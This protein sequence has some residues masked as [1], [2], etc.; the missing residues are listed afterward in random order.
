MIKKRYK[1]YWILGVAIISILLFSILLRDKPIV[2]KNEILLDAAIDGNKEKVQQL[3]AEEVDP[4][5]QGVAYGSALLYAAGNG[6]LEIVRFLIEKGAKVN[7]QNG[8]GSTPLMASASRGHDEIVQLLLEKGADIS[9][10]DTAGETAYR[11][12][13]RYGYPTTAALIAKYC[14]SQ[15]C[16]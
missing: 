14:P 1:F 16:E 2:D 7:I 10:K 5:Y 8:F 9:L 13:I 15:K 11:N 4:N 3:I 6:H 12:A